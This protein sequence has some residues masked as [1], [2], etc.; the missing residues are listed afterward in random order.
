MFDV[1]SCVTVQLLSALFTIRHTWTPAWGGRV[2]RELILFC[3]AIC[4]FEKSFYLGRKLRLT[5]SGMFFAAEKNADNNAD[6][7]KSGEHL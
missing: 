2:S 5:Y 3:I 1:C 7:I 4:L 6:N